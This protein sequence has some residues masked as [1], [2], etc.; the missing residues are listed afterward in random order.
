MVFRTAPTTRAPAARAGW[1]MTLVL[2]ACALPA[3]PQ[4]APGP[5]AAAAARPLL[6]QL[7]T[8]AW[9]TTSD[10]AEDRIADVAERAVKAV[11][12]IQTERR[13]SVPMGM[14]PGGLPFGWMDPRG[15]PQGPGG[16]PPGFDAPRA[17][18]QGSGV[19]V[20][21]SGV[22]VTNHHVVEGAERLT[23]T[24]SDGRRFEGRV[25][26]SDAATDL[27]VVTLDG[28]VPGDL[29]A[30]KWGDDGALR[31]GQVVLAI[32][33]PFGLSGSVT[34]GI[35]SAKGR[36]GMGIVDYEAFIQTDA[37]INPG[38]SGG[39]LVDL[40]GR[41]IG[42][43]T[44]IHSRSGGNDGIGFAIPA[45]LAR[46]VVDRL[47]REGEVRRGY[48]GVGIQDLDPA[49]AASFGLPDGTRGTLVNHVEPGSAAAE[50]G[51][52]TGDVIVSLDGV[53]ADGSGPLRN[54]LSLAGD[55]AK[56]SLGVVRDGAERTLTARLGALPGQPTAR[57]R[58][59]R[60]SD[61]NGPAGALVGV[62]TVPLDDALRARLGAPSDLS[63]VVVRD[64][65]PDSPAARAGLRPGDVITRVGREP[66]DG[67]GALARLSTPTALQVWRQGAT[68][69]L[70]LR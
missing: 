32:G 19:I 31:L 23:V 17:S 1:L 41:L 37:A 51:L 39:A 2:S 34:M 56:V 45:S 9:A 47:L 53:A 11:V 66:V 64:L 3:A 15:M 52:R 61:M 60:G 14:G 69:Y 44:A 70:F 18:G 58:G 30:L 16:F 68:P 28:A 5:E 40:E 48:L 63:G 27:A 42:V 35:V 21:A 59:P 10:L 65:D 6:D 38:N 24:L 55:G 36:S 12:G 33:N 22:I 8:P 67:P 43:N 46:T 4:A 49:F 25:R 50:A 20:A 26:A 13:M 62:T 54:A 57:S 29:P 7:V